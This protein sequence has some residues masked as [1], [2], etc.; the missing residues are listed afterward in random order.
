VFFVVSPL[1]VVSHIS[2]CVTRDMSV[3]NSRFY[4][5]KIADLRAKMRSMGGQTYGGA[6]GG[7]NSEIIGISKFGDFSGGSAILGSLRKTF[8]VASRSQEILIFRTSEALCLLSF[9]KLH[10]GGS[11]SNLQ[12][13][14]CVI[15]HG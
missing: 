4:I 2:D 8:P 13:V 14:L 7:L 1:A 11:E 12:N 9:M 15:G 5:R 6:S 10:V 3:R